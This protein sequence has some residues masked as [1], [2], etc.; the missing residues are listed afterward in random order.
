MGKPKL[1]IKIGTGQSLEAKNYPFKDLKAPS[2][3]ET[4]NV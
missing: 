1:I 4:S 2:L 3:D